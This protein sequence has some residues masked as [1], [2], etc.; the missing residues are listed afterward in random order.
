MSNRGRQN[1]ASFLVHDLHVDWRLGAQWFEHTLLDHDPASN[2]G[3]WVCA[4]G[5][6]M[7]GQRLNK[8][9]VDKQANDYDPDD[10]FVN[11][12]LRKQQPSSHKLVASARAQGV[13]EP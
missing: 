9:N 10:E 4:A 6:G 2:Y 8:F 12:W 1:V 3:N 13:A 11:L 5:V 7:A